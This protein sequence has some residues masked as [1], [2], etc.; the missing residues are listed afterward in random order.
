MRYALLFLLLLAAPVK[1][2]D[3]DPTEAWRPMLSFIGSWNATRSGA[4]FVRT[5]QSAATNHHLEVTE[6]AGGHDSSVWGIVSFDQGRG[7]LILR[8]FG[9]DG[10]TAEAQLDFAGST[11]DQ[12]VF[13]GKDVRITYLRSGWNAFVERVEHGST[14]VSETKFVRKG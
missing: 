2:A 7:G 1:A 4:K 3:V 6:K 11:P 14:L 9:A 12:L 10:S 8:Q 5:Y 13:A